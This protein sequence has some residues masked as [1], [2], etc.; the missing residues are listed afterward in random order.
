MAEQISGSKTNKNPLVLTATAQEVL[1]ARKKAEEEESNAGNPAVPE[2]QGIQGYLKDIYEDAKAFKETETDTQ[3]V[4]ID[5][6][7]RKN[8]EYSQTKLSDIK[9][10]NSATTYLPITGVKCRAL[11]AFIRDIYMNA[12]RKRTWALKPTPIATLPDE[13][14]KK[15]M[16]DVME[17]ADQDPEMDQSQAFKLASDMRAEM[18]TREYVVALERAENMARLVDDQLIEGGFVKALAE[19]IMDISTFPAMVI[20]GPIMRSRRVR[21]G[22]KDGKIQYKDK[23]VPTFERVS[24]LD[25][26]PSRYASDVDDGT[27]LCEKVAIN[28]G[29]LVAN[30]NKKG[31]Y[32]E[33][34]EYV[35]AYSNN[36]GEDVSNQDAER[37]EAE[38]KD[39]PSSPARH[40]TKQV[41]NTLQGIEYYASVRGSDLIDFGVIKDGNGKAIDT[42]LDYEINAITISHRIVFLD[43]NKAVNQKRPYSVSG[44][45]KE[46]GGFWYKPV[47]MVLKDIQD[48]VNASARALVN[49][50]A[51]SSGP[52]VIIPDINR[53]A[54]GE[55]ITSIYVGKIWQGTNGGAAGAAKLVDFYQ[56][57]SRSAELIGIINQFITLA[58]QLIE[59]PSYTTGNDK[60]SGAG[61]TSSGLSM[62]MSASNRGM[63]RMILDMD[64]NV[65]ENIVCT[66]VDMNLED[67]KVDASKKGDLN[68]YSEGVVSLMMKEQLA[69]RQMSLLASTNNEFDMKIIGLDGRAKILSKA[70]ESIEADYDDIMPTPEK[71]EKLLAREETLQQQQI[72]ENQ[73]KIEKERALTEREA[74]VAQAEIEVSL[75]KLELEKRAQDIQ[76]NTDSRELD[77][78]AEKQTSDRIDKLAK[79]ELEKQ[80]Q[81][82]EEAEPEGQ[83]VINAES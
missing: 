10:V 12:K 78:R 31:Y 2:L 36:T 46:I 62:L 26:Y 74:E 59:M 77:I 15:I 17:K 53:L 75:Q 66:M 69:E 64:R 71:I 41:G 82:T 24:P 33:N 55:D 60:V 37:E 47:P 83:E 72:E 70:M 67:P 35:A 28:R 63:K 14:K 19:G 4:M 1:D 81:A 13:A 40:G 52:Q 80:K 5:C 56:P 22:W 73:A 11:E 57:D 21:D 9:S 79:I 27:P 76:T 50:L 16:A 3:D 29:S 43:F 18:I 45:S 30:R 34:I 65:I 20:K 51:W 44:F 39:Q 49:N 61:R 68:F 48:V 23:I 25:L 38:T 32:K 6:L 8:G 54:P 42:F 58:D 7:L